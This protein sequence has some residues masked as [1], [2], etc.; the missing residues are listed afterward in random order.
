MPSKTLRPR[1]VAVW[2]RLPL[3]QMYFEYTHMP[4][5]QFCRAE[6]TSDLRVVKFVRLLCFREK[7][8]AL[9]YS[10]ATR[11]FFMGERLDLGAMQFNR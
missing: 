10:W 7:V 5:L 4:S 1:S 2:P 9:V 6:Q 3:Q 11:W 8:C